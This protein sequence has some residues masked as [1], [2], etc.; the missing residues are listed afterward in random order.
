MPIV[1][2]EKATESRKRGGKAFYLLLIPPV[3]VL[4][5]FAAAV[6]RPVELQ[7]G[8]VVV[9]ALT[10]RVPGTPRF[11][12]GGSPVPVNDPLEI[13][14]HSY[15]V[16]GSGWGGAVIVAGWGCGIGWFSGHRK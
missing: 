9:V 10:Q 7:L 15:V 14:G 3:L 6:V 2:E 16:T 12:A 11:Y 1:A 13:E 5:L 8:P 4:L